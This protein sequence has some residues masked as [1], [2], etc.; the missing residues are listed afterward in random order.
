MWNMPKIIAWWS[1]EES[2]KVKL[3]KNEEKPWSILPP[4]FAWFRIP[5]DPDMSLS[6]HTDTFNAGISV[7][8][9]EK[10]VQIIERSHSSKCNQVN[11]TII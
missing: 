6:A 1:F 9:K 3:E 8:R 10:K 11:Y 5:D 4:I 2:S 7:V